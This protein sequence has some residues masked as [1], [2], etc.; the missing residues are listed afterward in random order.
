MF[1]E[2][3]DQWCKLGKTNF[4]QTDWNKAT[5]EICHL[6]QRTTQKNMEIMSENISR[7][8]DIFKRLCNAKKPEDFL[9]LQRECFN[10]SMT[11][12]IHCMQE[13][14]STSMENMDECSKLF[15]SFAP[16]HETGS[17]TKSYERE[18]EKIN[19]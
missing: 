7:C 9:Q 16:H 3:F 10:E 4:A 11:A 19:R 13:L 18:K 14:I 5:N 1:I 2:S 15:A 6:C 8:S 12:C 17:A